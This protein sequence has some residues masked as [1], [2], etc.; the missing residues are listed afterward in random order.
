M[1]LFSPLRPALHYITLI[2]RPPQPEVDMPEILTTEELCERL[3]VHRNTVGRWREEGLPAMARGRGY[4]YRW[5]DVAAWLD[6]PERAGYL[7]AAT[8]PKP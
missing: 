5:D 7:A 3:G 4:V 2:H 6:T 1:N 8:E